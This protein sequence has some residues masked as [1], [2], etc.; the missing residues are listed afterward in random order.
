MIKIFLFA[1]CSKLLVPND[2]W[3]FAK[4]NCSELLSILLCQ[5]LSADDLWPLLLH[6][7]LSVDNLG[8]PHEIYPL[9]SLRNLPWEASPLRG[10]CW[11]TA[12]C[13]PRDLKGS[14][15]GWL[16]IGLRDDWLWRVYFHSGRNS[17]Q[18]ILAPSKVGHDPGSRSFGYS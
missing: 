18:V 11:V 7:H 9:K 4:S 10:R 12:C 14:H 5:Y 8:N 3:N 17:C 13:N 15:L 16:F 1:N 6:Q 2:L